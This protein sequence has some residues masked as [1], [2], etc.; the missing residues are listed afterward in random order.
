MGTETIKAKKTCGSS[1]KTRSKK[2]DIQLVKLS[3]LSKHELSRINI[4]NLW[5]I[6]PIEENAKL[7]VRQC[8]CKGVCQAVMPVAEPE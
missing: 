7:M 1:Q 2:Q 8:G 5:I 3:N 6:R 4:D